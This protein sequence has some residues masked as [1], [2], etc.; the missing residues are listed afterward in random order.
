MNSLQE[1]Q[2]TT[3][4]KM[5][6]IQVQFEEIRDEAKELLAQLQEISKTTFN[7]QKVTLEKGYEDAKEVIAA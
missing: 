4:A 2:D 6:K 3:L 1:T 7:K 5:N